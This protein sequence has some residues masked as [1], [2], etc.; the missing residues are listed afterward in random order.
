MGHSR[1]P[2][3]A[4]GRDSKQTLN[5][6]GGACMNRKRH[7]CHLVTSLE[8]VLARSDD[9]FES[10]MPL[11]GPEGGQSADVGCRSH[12]IARPAKGPATDRVSNVPSD[13]LYTFR[14]HF[15]MES[16]DRGTFLTGFVE[17]MEKHRLRGTAIHVEP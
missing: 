3:A 4:A 9:C 11:I 6:D 15:E 1:H 8:T 10:S 14:S 7:L 17:A 16:I 12:Q 5:P 13:R 2:C